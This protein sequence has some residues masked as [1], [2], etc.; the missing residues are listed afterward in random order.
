MNESSTMRLIALLLFK[1]VVDKLSIEVKNTQ[2]AFTLMTF[3]T[4]V[5]ILKL[6]LVLNI[7]KLTILPS[8][9][10]NNSQV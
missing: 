7:D 1:A 5:L 9:L 6:S 8:N 3:K 10:N 4:L 2:Q